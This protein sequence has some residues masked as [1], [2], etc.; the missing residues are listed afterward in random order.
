MSINNHVLHTVSLPIFSSKLLQ[1]KESGTNCITRANADMIIIMLLLL[2]IISFTTPAVYAAN[3][4]F[5]SNLGSGISLGSPYNFSTYGAWQAIN[6]T[7]K[8]TGYTWPVSALG[9]DFSGV[10]LITV[11]PITSSTIGNYITNE[12]RSVTGPDGRPVNEL[13]QQVKIKSPVGAGGTQAPLVINRPWN[14]GDVDNLY[15]S[16]QFKYQADFETQL[17]S[18]VP[19]GNWRTHFEFKTGGY[20][21]SWP[22]DYRITIYVYKGSDG[23]LY[24]AT[25]GDNVANGPFTP[26]DYW[27]ETNHAVPVPVDK[28]SKFEVYWHRSGGSDGRYWAAIDGQVIVDHHGP[29]MGDY[30]LPITRIFVS[31]PYSGGN[32]SVDNHMT[33]LEIWNDFPCGAGVS[34]FDADSIAPTVPASLLAALKTITT[35]TNT[36]KG[37]GK[38]K[39]SSSA[40]VTLSWNASSDNVAVAGYNIYRNGTKI[41]VSTSTGY[42]DSLGVATGSVYSYTVKAFDAAGNISTASN[43]ASIVN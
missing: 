28:W 37:K 6:G 26:T 16:Y 11:D 7:D 27:I 19:G 3:L 33:G 10:Q 23:K 42:T 38:T 20:N 29:N 41:A 18:T 40:Q 25:K 22:G 14:I 12:I 9:S 35:T 15:I 8:E 17:D 36:S 34:C 1:I 13:F 32:V 2:T 39:S 4:L 30:N 21:N 31:N 43:V 24:W 5:R